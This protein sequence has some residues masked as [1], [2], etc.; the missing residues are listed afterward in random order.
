MQTARP[1]K[2]GFVIVVRHMA[3]GERRVISASFEAAWFT[4]RLWEKEG[5]SRVTALE[6]S[7]IGTCNLSS[8]KM[9]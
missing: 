9:E 3:V 2:L 4:N 6:F 7:A 5:K 1:E 8:G